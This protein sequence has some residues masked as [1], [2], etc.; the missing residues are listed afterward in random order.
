MNQC[1]GGLRM[2]DQCV[3]SPQAFLVKFFFL[4]LPQNK[5]KIGV[6]SSKCWRQIAES[7][8]LFRLKKQNW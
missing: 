8:Q 3:Q 7:K 4:E 5:M 1:L 6:I 2:E